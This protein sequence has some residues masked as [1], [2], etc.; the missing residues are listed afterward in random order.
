MDSPTALLRQF[1][2]SPTLFSDC[3]AP[4]QRSAWLVAAALVVGCG[5]SSKR[6]PKPPKPDLSAVGECGSVGTSGQLSASPSLRRADRDL[7]ADG[8][9]ELVAADRNLCR[10]ENCRWN[11]FGWDGKCHR[12][13]GTIDGAAIEKGSTLGEAGYPEIRSWWRLGDGARALLHVYRF[14]AGGY[15]LVE[16]L[17][18]RTAEGDGI[19]CALEESL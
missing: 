9:D 12:Y 3:S 6:A 10:G 2:A 15:R 5:G 4:S 16:T 13:L 11:L 18:C 7:D 1:Q 14:G 17:M 8:R 19:E